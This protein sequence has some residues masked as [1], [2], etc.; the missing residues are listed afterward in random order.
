MAPSFELVFDKLWNVIFYL[1]PIGAEIEGMINPLLH[2]PL[3]AFSGPQEENS[4]SRLVIL[5]NVQ[6]SASGSY[7]LRM[8]IKNGP[9]ID[10]FV[11][12]QGMNVIGE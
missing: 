6:D 8:R 3:P 2:A 1:R 12:V 10:D 9:K 11:Q 5:K 4:T 7:E